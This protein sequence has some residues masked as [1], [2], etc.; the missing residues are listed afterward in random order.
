M[1]VKQALLLC[2][3]AVIR[4]NLDLFFSW[5]LLSVHLY[6]SQAK[7][8]AFVLVIVHTGIALACV[9]ACIYPMQRPGLTSFSKKKLH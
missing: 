5:T 2:N 3:K 1:V 8:A 7:L 4:G 6:N 9:A